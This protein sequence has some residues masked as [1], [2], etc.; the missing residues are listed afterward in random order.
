MSEKDG[1][2]DIL[3]VRLVEVD[4][5]FMSLETN[6]TKPTLKANKKSCEKCDYETESESDL[7]L[8]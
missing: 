5:K 4:V 2:I 8:H 6:F 1:Q 7:D 3:K